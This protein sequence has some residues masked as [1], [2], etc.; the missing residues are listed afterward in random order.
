VPVIARGDQFVLGHDL[1]KVAE[2]VGVPAPG[3]T[4]LPPGVLIAR[5]IN[6]L[7]AAQRYVRQFPPD[8]LNERAIER[9]DRSIRIL[10]HHVFRIAEAFL[11]CVIGG[12]EYSSGLVDLEP[13]TGR[14]E[15]V[16][17]IADYGGRIIERLQQWWDDAGDGSSGSAVQTFY[18]PQS[19]HQLLERSTWHS[20][21]HV[22]QLVDLLDRDHIIPDGRLVDEDLAG[23]PLPDAIFE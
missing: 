17:E 10:T 13:E 3:H 11:E 5:W 23:L 20:A 4:P 7:R 18:G 8:R 9:R 15:T 2:F 12:V 22:R 19:V 21:Q 6:I 16:D 14:C 1:A